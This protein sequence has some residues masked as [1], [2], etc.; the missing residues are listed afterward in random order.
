MKEMGVNAYRSAHRFAS[1]DLLEI[2][3]EYGIL[4][5]NENRIPESSPWRLADL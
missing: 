2:C 1:K 3:D 5:M 4:M